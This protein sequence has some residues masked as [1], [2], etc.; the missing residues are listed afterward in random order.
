[1]V[2]SK[3][4]YRYAASIVYNNFPWPEPCNKQRAAIEAAAQTVLDERARYPESTLADLYD[5]ISMPVGLVRAHQSLD[6]AV[7]VAYGRTTFASEAERV[8]FLFT[9]Y[10]KMTSL[11]ITEKPKT[12]RRRMTG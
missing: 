7:D 8:A 5:P 3:S 11:F 10:E 12:R 4:D 6:R 1:M 2:D 9:L